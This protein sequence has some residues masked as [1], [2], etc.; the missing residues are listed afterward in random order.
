MKHLHKRLLEFKEINNIVILF[1]KIMLSYNQ[2]N[3]K[4]DIVFDCLCSSN[5]PLLYFNMGLSCLALLIL[6]QTQ[7]QENCLI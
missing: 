5:L 3:D 6:P 4:M 7:S 2:Y 1:C